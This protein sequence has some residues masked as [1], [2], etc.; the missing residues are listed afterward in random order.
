MA[1]LLGEIDIAELESLDYAARSHVV[2]SPGSNQDKAAL[3][4]PPSRWL[5]WMIPGESF[6]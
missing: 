4:G 2:V 5:R 3:G 6:G 1:G